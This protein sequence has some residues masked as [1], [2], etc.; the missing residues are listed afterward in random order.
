MSRGSGWT[1]R[2]S[3]V[4]TCGRVLRTRTGAVAHVTT[5]QRDGKAHRIEG[6]S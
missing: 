5:A 3:F 6:I 4:C 2:W 1:G